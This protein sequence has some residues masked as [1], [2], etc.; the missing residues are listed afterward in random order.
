MNIIIMGG[1]GFIGTNLALKLAQRESKERIIIVDTHNEYF[2]EEL[3]RNY[4][5]IIYEVSLFDSRADYETIL[6]KYKVDIV[7]NLVSTT[8][9]S[10]ANKNIAQEINSNV[11][12]SSR[13]FEACVNC[14]VKRVVFI[15]SGGTVY[16][17]NSQCPISEEAPLNPINSYGF[18]K[19]SIEKLLYIYKYVYGLEYVICRLSNP[20]G[21]YQRP[22]G[23]L[24]VITTFIYKAIKKEPLIVYGDGSVVRDFLYIDDAINCLCK[25]SFEKLEYEI[26]NVGSGV[27]VD[28]NTIISY[29]N[30][31]LGYHS[32]VIYDK[33]RNVDVPMNYLD[34]SRYESEFGRIQQVDLREG[35][36]ITHNYLRLLDAQ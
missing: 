26:Y 27:G 23:L 7:F 16:G 13:L 17:I 28:I 29:I 10:N 9:P 33:A 35:I 6:K 32:E 19:M 5:N 1:A 18:Q 31:V 4:D 34:V 3:F 15:S 12:F 30:E 8:F 24:G 36:N 20:Y 25:L 14:Q 2:H 11:E 22:N 21:P